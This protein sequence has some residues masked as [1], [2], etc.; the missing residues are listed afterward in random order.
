MGKAG[1]G[2]ARTRAFPDGVWER[3]KTSVNTG[4]IIPHCCTTNRIKDNDDDENGHQDAERVFTLDES[5]EEQMH[6]IKGIREKNY[7]TRRPLFRFRW[8]EVIQIKPESHGKKTN[9]ADI[10]NK[11]QLTR[12]IDAK[13][14]SEPDGEGGRGFFFLRFSLFTDHGATYGGAG[15]RTRGISRGGLQSGEANLTRR[16][17]GGRSTASPTRAF[18]SA[19]WERGEHQTYETYQTHGTTQQRRS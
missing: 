6:H 11:R 17:G 1:N 16:H 13:P 7:K 18:P 9:S 12:K 15:G 19:T 4:N 5:G 2:V 14:P 8:K 10:I 3:E